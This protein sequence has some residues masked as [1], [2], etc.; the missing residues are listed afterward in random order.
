MGTTHAF[1]NPP[2]RPNTKGVVL[3]EDGSMVWS[4]NAVVKI[5]KCGT[6]ARRFCIRIAERSRG[7]AGGKLRV[8]L[9]V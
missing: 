6:G 3:A 9:A 4:P 1:V 5:V 8:S 7:Y 2:F